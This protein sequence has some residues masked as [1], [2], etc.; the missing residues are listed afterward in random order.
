MTNEPG[1]FGRQIVVLEAYCVNGRGKE[2]ST[3]RREFV[4]EPGTSILTGSMFEWE[5]QVPEDTRSIRVTLSRRVRG[6]D[7]AQVL[8]ETEIRL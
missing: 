2:I 6:G 8:V 3:A 1:D 7:G 5:F 4:K